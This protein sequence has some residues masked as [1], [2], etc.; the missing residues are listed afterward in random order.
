LFC[1]FLLSFFG[2]LTQAP[3]PCSLNVRDNCVKAGCRQGHQDTNPV[4]SNARPFSG[5][6]YLLCDEVGTLD[7]P[8]ALQQLLAADFFAAKVE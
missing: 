4:K 6:F 2:I 3:I 7:W 5:L 8:V 1:F